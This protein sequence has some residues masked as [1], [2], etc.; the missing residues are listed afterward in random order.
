MNY[1]AVRIKLGMQVLGKEQAFK[2]IKKRFNVA[3]PVIDESYGAIPMGEIHGHRYAY[4]DDYVVQ[5]DADVALKLR[6]E[7]HPNIISVME[8]HMVD[9]EYRDGI[10]DE[11]TK[12]ELLD[13][14]Q[15]ARHARGAAQ[16]I[17]GIF[18]GEEGVVDNISVE[19][20]E[21]G[22]HARFLLKRAPTAEEEKR[23]PREYKCVHAAPTRIKYDISGTP[24]ANV[25]YKDALMVKGILRDRFHAAQNLPVSGIGL[26]QH[27]DRG[28][29]VKVRLWRLPTA[30]EKKYL[31][32]ESHGVYV[33]YRIIP[34]KAV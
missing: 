31:P 3:A 33:R 26:D 28:Y 8:D 19:R 10:E 32:N 5:M 9:C 13:M 27:D 2:E 29:H 30:A 11:D 16:T 22:Y 15:T 4:K 12:V 25:T 18:K 1:V 24:E 6:S 7:K 14:A 34:P 17:R 20:D 23:L 21:K